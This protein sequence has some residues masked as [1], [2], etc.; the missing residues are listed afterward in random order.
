VA[1]AARDAVGDEVV[2]IHEGQCSDEPT[3]PAY[4]LEDLD[5]TGRSETTI[6]A[7]LSDLTTGSYAIAIHRSAE[8]YGEIVACGEIPRN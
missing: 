7:P 5:A 6:A 2:V 3:L 1:I 4:L 8:A